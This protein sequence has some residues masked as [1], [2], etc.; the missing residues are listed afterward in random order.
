MQAV[1]EQGV[2]RMEEAKRQALDLLSG[3]RDGDAVTVLAAGTSF[4]PVVS[5]STDHALAEH[6]IRSLE[7]GNGGADLS[8]ALSLAAAMKRETFG[9]EIYV[10]PTAPWKSRKTRTCARWE[11]ARPT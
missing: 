5:R 3:M 7:A 1:N 8:G 11:K 9:M 6:A 10:S 4:S 2:S